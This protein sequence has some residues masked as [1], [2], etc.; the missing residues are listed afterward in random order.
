MRLYKYYGNISAIEIIGLAE[1]IILKELNNDEKAPVYLK[2]CGALAKYIYDLDMTDA[3]ERYLNANWYYDRGLYLCRIEIPST[4]PSLPAKVI[5]QEDYHNDKL[6]IFGPEKY[7]ETSNPAP[8][9]KETFW[10][11]MRWKSENI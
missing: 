4:T 5:T 11:W 7:I 9:S 6:I 3:E 2:V 1:F 8:M 10:E